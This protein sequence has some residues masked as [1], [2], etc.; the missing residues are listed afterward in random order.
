[1]EIVYFSYSFFFLMK[2]E[3]TGLLLDLSRW[4]NSE[5]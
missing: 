5:C 1:M 4:G 2:E 3:K